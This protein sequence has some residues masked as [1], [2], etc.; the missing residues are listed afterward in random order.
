ME[1]TLQLDK[2]TVQILKDMKKKSGA[3]SYDEVIRVLILKE[4]KVPKS[5]F[6]SNPRLGPF[7]EEDRAEIREY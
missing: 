5:I 4:R 7:K 1:T 3:R 2:S 6:G